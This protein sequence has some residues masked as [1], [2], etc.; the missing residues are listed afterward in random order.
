MCIV[1]ALALPPT[2]HTHYAISETLTCTHCCTAIISLN[3]VSGKLIMSRYLK[4]PSWRM[5]ACP[6]NIT[7][8]TVLPYS[9]PSS[10]PL[11]GKTAAR[12]V[13]PRTHFDPTTDHT[14]TRLTHIAQ[15]H[16]YVYK[17]ICFTLY[18]I[19]ITSEMLIVWVSNVV[20]CSSPLVGVKSVH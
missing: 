16:T 18:M 5:M 1:Y 9:F 8:N 20:I 10:S 15:P 4:L 17:Y 12:I 7:P 14:H 6:R 13:V 3:S 2:T 11:Y 19:S